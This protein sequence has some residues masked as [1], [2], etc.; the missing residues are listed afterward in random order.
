MLTEEYVTRYNLSGESQE[1]I[2]YLKEAEDLARRLDDQR[3][4]RWLPPLFPSTSECSANLSVL[5]RPAGAPFMPNPF[6][7]FQC[8]RS[9][10]LPM[11]L[12]S[13]R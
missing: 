5:Q 12:L 10:N 11:G 3:R 8:K 13:Y 7:I 6:Q 9:L 2:G 4:L 1:I